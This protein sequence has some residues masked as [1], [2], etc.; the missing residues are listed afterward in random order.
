MHVEVSKGPLVQIDRHATCLSRLEQNLREPLELTQRSEHLASELAHIELGDLGATDVPDVD[1]VK[2]DAR[3][4]DLVHLAQLYVLE[5]KARVREAVPKRIRDRHGGLLVVSVAHVD[6][7]SVRRHGAIAR[8]VV[9]GRG[10][11]KTLGPGLGQLA[12]GVD[13]PREHVDCGGG[14]RL[15]A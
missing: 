9:I 10:V 15:P 12:R 5:G 2:R 1:D 6:A 11:R 13:L 3:A 14:T 7:L 8:K 4:R